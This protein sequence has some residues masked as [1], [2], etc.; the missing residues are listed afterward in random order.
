MSSIKQGIAW[1]LLSQRARGDFENPAEGHLTQTHSRKRLLEEMT[2]LNCE[3][4]DVL[5]E[6][7]E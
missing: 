4:N 2:E 6:E 3:I 5:C 1:F 7:C